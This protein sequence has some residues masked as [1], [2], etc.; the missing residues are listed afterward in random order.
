M[1]ASLL[2]KFDKNQD[3]QLDAT[4]M[5]ALRAE[6]NSAVVAS[7]FKRPGGP[8]G[9]LGRG[10]RQVPPEILQT[11]DVDK[12]GTLNESERAALKQ[13]VQDGKVTPP[14][15]RGNG[16]KG[17]PKELVEKYDTDGDGVLSATEREALHQAEGFGPRHEMRGR[18]PHGPGLR[19][20][21]TEEQ[22]QEQ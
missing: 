4:E 20:P 2:D 3:G 10:P 15:G 8:K 1:L 13:D 9:G 17:P 11:Y 6:L 12:D 5:T 22:A 18:G 21:A 7:E 19:A 14:R 16:P